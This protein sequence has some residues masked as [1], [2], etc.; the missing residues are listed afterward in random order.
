MSIKPKSQL[1]RGNKTT[2]CKRSS[3]VFLKSAK[4]I[5]QETTLFVEYLCIFFLLLLIIF[6]I[7]KPEKIVLLVLFKFIFFDNSNCSSSLLHSFLVLTDS[8]CSKQSICIV[9]NIFFRLR[10]PER[11]WLKERTFGF[12]NGFQHHLGS[13]IKW[14]IMPVYSWEIYFQSK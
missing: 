1:A 13:F 2:K 9:P 10:H 11:N 6:K 12:E 8:P 3:K 4:S 7:C 5:R 14:K